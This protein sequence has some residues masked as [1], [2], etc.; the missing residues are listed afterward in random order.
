[1]E[2]GKRRMSI[3]Q[4]GKFAAALGME[5]ELLLYEAETDD[6]RLRY[7]DRVALSEVASALPHLPKPALTALLSTVR[8]WKR[9]A[10][11]VN[12]K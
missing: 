1:M 3:D 4:L 10:R 9:E 12:G 11:K 5:A 7:A 6:D 8:I 2:N